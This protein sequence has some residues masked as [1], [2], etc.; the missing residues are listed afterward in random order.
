MAMERDRSRNW[1]RYETDVVCG[2]FPSSRLNRSPVKGSH[3]NFSLSEKS[4]RE[5]R[6]ERDV[7]EKKVVAGVGAQRRLVHFSRKI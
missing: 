6:K 5:E 3:L 2:T 7:R 1:F 4:R